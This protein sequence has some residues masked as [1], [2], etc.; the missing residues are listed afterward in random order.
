M[1]LASVGFLLGVL[2]CQSLVKLPVTEW[3]L[4]ILILIPAVFRFPRYRFFIFIALGFLYSVF[5]AHGKLENQL[6]AKLEGKDLLI[7]GI[8][9][10]LPDR[11]ADH[12]RFIFT[13]SDYSELSQ[14][15]KQVSVAAADKKPFIHRLRLS[16][17]K[18]APE[19]HV[20]QRWQLLVRL[21]R[22]HGFSNPGGFDYEAWLFQHGIDATGYVRDRAKS[23]YLNQFLGEGSGLLNAINRERETLSIKVSHLVAGAQAGIIDALL[24]GDRQYIEPQQWRILTTTGTNHLMAISGLHIGLVAGLIFF[25]VNRLWPRIPKA[26]LYIASPRMAALCAIAAAIVYAA[27]AGFTLPTQRAVIMISIAMLAIWRQQPIVA[28]QVLATALLAVLL[29]DPTAVINGSFWLSFAAV[30]IIFYTMLGRISVRNWWWK[31]GRVQW[32]IAIGLSPIVIF[33]YQQISL[34][35]PIANLLAVPLVSLVTVPLS[36]L[37]GILLIVW[38]F[39]L[40]PPLAQGILSLAV[41]SLDMLWPILR[42]LADQKTFIVSVGEPPIWALIFAVLG[43]VYLL[44]PRGFPTRSVGIFWLFPFIFYPKHTLSAGELQLTVLDVGQGLSVVV[45]TRHHVLVYDAGPR[46]GAQLDAGSMVVVPYLKNQGIQHIDRLVLSHEDIDHTGGFHSIQNSFPIDEVV[47]TPGMRRS[48]IHWQYCLTGM[49]WEWDKVQFRVLSPDA[50][51][52]SPRDNNRSCVVQITTE[53]DQILLTGDIER[54]V[55]THL[56]KFFASNDD[57]LRADILLVPHHGSRSSS[58]QAFVQAVKP[59]YALISAGYRNRYGLPKDDVLGRYRATGAKVLDTRD[60]G[61]I[62][63]WLDREGVTKIVNN[64][65]LMKHYWSNV[66]N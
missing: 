30:S 60:S 19:L 28:S 66:R 16:W 11:A 62:S 24:V 37:A 49:S 63:V 48:H 58:S 38:P 61:A 33:W 6:S 10:S 21:K 34:L 41:S 57:N 53:N 17:Y 14:L 45:Q 35:S 22:P 51:S 18:T 64:R 13:S 31:W 26:A 23:S 40:W 55:E 7:H 29:Y 3:C 27:L 54:Q 47:L 52:M 36:L 25:L 1:Q 2:G 56:V 43:I 12:S 9:T 20:G 15:K 32:V 4:I 65:S 46:F 50:G 59:K 44:A 5:I 42:L 39:S 8:I